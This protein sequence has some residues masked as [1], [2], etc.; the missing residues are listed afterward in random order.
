MVAPRRHPPW[1]RYVP[2]A[3]SAAE[4][5][6]VLHL[7]L[8]RVTYDAAKAEVQITFRPCG[9]RILAERSETA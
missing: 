2:N 5:A 1:L 8:E 4:K 6:R 3:L 7:L 9:V